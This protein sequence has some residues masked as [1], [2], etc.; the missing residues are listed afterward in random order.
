MY[1]RDLPLIDIAGRGGPAALVMEREDYMFVI[2]ASGEDDLAVEVLPQSVR[3]QSHWPRNAP[4]CQDLLSRLEKI[5]NF[6]IAR[7]LL[8]KRKVTYY[9]Y[10]MESGRS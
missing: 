3:G 8:T 7:F 9:E 4:V 5:R 2:G 1:A 6:P 10:V